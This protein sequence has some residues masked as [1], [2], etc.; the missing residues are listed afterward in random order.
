MYYVPTV[1]QAL[2]CLF[3]YS[4]QIESKLLHQNNEKFSDEA[5]GEISIM[6]DLTHS[7]LE[8][9][10][11]I[12]HE[13]LSNIVEKVDIIEDSID[14]TTN[15]FTNNQLKRLSNKTCT[16]EH[17]VIFTKTLTDFERIG[18]HGLNIAKSFSKVQNLLNAMKMVKP[19]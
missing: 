7:I 18:D 4:L 13:E 8:E 16:T 15:E 2:D 5:L 19:E 1:C 12:S 11:I 17:S 9:L 14:A 10:K 3:S 6:S